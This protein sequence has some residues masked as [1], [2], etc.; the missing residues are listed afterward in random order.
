MKL[1]LLEQSENKVVL[2]MKKTSAVFANMIRREILEHVPS[3]AI[4]HVEIRRN[5][6]ALYDEMLALRLGL[7]P[8]ITDLDSYKMPSLEQKESGEFDARTSLILTLQAK[9]PCT[10]YASDI[11]SKDPKVIPAFPKMPIAKLLKGQEIELEAT[12]VLGV[13][14][15]H[16]KFAPGLAFYSHARK[17]KQV[18]KVDNPEEVVAKCPA[19][20]FTVKGGNIEPVSEVTSHLW[21]TILD[22]TSKGSFTVE[23]IEDEFIFTLESFGQLEP[24]AILDTV[25]SGFKEQ[26]QN[27]EKVA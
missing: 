23:S 1:E 16:M 7:L 11:V 15:E 22:V 6:G 17:F 24:K 3:M 13:G 26:L 8:L 18:K 19:G 12:A 9:G 25:F 27:F 2:K 21:D 10:V 4:E 20:V 14:M 5:N